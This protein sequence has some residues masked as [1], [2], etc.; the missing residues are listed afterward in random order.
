MT[1]VVAHLVASIPSP[2]E[3]T[4]NIGPLKIHAYGLMIALGVVAGVWLLGK[5]LEDKGIGTKDDANSIAVWAVIMG[6]I[7]SRLYHVA[8]DWSKF[9][10]HLSDIP[11]IWQGGLGIPGGLLFGIPT[12]AYMIRRKGIPV[13]RAI[14]CAAPAIAIAQ[15][16]GRWGN[17]WNQ[18]LF[19][20]ATKLPWGLEIDD[21]HLPAGYAHGT[22]FQPTFLYESLLNLL[23][24]AGLLL[25]DRKRKVPPGHLMAMYLM[26]YGVIR[27][28]V[29]GL[30]I[31]EAHHVGGLRWNQW[32]ALA[33]VI[34]GGVYLALSNRR[35]AAALTDG[36]PADTTD[37][38]TTDTDT[39]TEATDS[40]DVE[41]TDNAADTTD[42]SD[43][44]EDDVEP[45]V[46]VDAVGADAGS[47]E[48]ASDPA[49]GGDDGL[50][51]SHD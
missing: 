12:G 4:L 17:Y 16:I 10:H 41:T 45:L 9:A 5:R 44:S 14:D 18:E 39:D 33:M 35:R 34:G 13:A 50:P 32:V 30:R 31:D 7:G 43:G 40:T 47:G 27:F 37:T 24:A 2:S 46:H 29:E 36:E 11:K 21:A 28:F 15:A 49:G 6:V 48:T 26:G 1:G 22:L 19:G 25:I 8:T 42:G 3:G 38:D 51:S 23:L 20:K